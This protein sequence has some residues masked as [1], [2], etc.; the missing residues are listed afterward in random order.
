[1][2]IQFAGATAAKT[3]SR[4]AQASYP[5]AAPCLIWAA[6][7]KAVSWSMKTNKD[8]AQAEAPTVFVSW[9]GGRGKDGANKYAFTFGLSIAFALG[10]RCQLTAMWQAS[11]A[12]KKLVKQLGLSVPPVV[13]EEL[14]QAA[15]QHLPH[16][17]HKS[18]DAA[19]CTL[20]RPL[21]YRF[22]MIWSIVG[23]DW[24]HVHSF[25]FL[26]SDHARLLGC[27]ICNSATLLNMEPNSGMDP[28][29]WPWL[30][31]MF[32]GCSAISSI[33]RRLDSSYFF[34]RGSFFE[35]LSIQKILWAIRPT[36]HLPLSHILAGRPSDPLCMWLYSLQRCMGSTVAFFAGLMAVSIW[37]NWC[38]AYDLVWE[39]VFS[40]PQ[41]WGT[42]YGVKVKMAFTF[43]GWHWHAPFCSIL[44]FLMVFHVRSFLLHSLLLISVDASIRK[45]LWKARRDIRPGDEAGWNAPKSANRFGFGKWCIASHR[46]PSAAG[47]HLLSSGGCPSALCRR[48]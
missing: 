22:D 32:I 12:V 1:M 25:V 16:H 19:T 11:D 20:V 30:R 42:E 24:D 4:V 43:S 37:I 6:L 38:F 8:V 21:K 44:W 27:R 46:F 7:C 14:L 47:V 18:L 45:L 2:Q 10:S 5:A 31:W 17:L 23:S 41:L 36:L 13:V 35:A 3:Q 48:A 28:E 9:T 39:L 15:W 33:W 29:L 26:W 34:F 40:T